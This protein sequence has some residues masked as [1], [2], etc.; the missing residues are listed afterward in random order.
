MKNKNPRRYF[1]VKT[2]G[3]FVELTHKKF[4]DMVLKT[5]GRTFIFG[6]RTSFYSF[7]SRSRMRDKLDW[8]CSGF[9]GEMFPAFL[10]IIKILTEK[11]K[12]DTDG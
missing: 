11:Q 2:R 4:A 7:R 6:N 8:V 3:G 12:G 9:G 5:K 1:W 10:K